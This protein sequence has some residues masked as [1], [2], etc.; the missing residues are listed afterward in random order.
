MNE[1]MRE[2]KTRPKL[3]DVFQEFRKLSEEEKKLLVSK[4]AFSNYKNNW[5]SMSFAEMDS[6][7][8]YVDS[9]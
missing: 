2:E 8:D 7:S 4:E 6:W 3:R 5:H 9:G 1:N